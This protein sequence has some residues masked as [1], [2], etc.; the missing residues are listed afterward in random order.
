MTSENR[1]NCIVCS[2][3]VKSCHRDILQNMSWV[4]TPKMYKSE[5]KAT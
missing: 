3:I 1:D 2:K 5:T 4:N